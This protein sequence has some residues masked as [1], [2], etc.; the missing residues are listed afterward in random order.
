M[1]DKKTSALAQC[2]ESMQ[3][4]AIE[5]EKPII[6]M[7]QYNKLFSELWDKAFEYGRQIG[8]GQNIIDHI[9]PKS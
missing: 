8:V 5:N 2:I 6:Q 1:I 4:V 7:I 9:K 3:M